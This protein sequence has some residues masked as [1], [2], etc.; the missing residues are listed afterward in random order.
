[1]PPGIY[2]KRKRSKQ[3]PSTSFILSFASES[4]NVCSLQNQSE[5][6]TISTLFR[7]RMKVVRYR[8]SSPSAAQVYLDVDL[9]S[10]QHV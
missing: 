2:N 8:A 1:M 10:P 3:P 4:V 9:I 5:A 6:M 7:S